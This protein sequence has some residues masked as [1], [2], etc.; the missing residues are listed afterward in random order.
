MQESK[1]K[2]LWE[3]ITA[4]GIP[5]VGVTAAKLLEQWFGSMERLLVASR[6]ELLL[7]P[8]I[9]IL[10]FSFCVVKWSSWACF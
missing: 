8:G 1:G 6:E 4:L 9:F 7:V 5:S 3:L 10:C 2:A